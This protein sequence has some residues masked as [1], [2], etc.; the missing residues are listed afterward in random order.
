M[1][2][3]RRL[4]SMIAI[5]ALAAAAVGGV[6]CSIVY[7]DMYLSEDKDGR[8][9]TEYG[10]LGVPGEYKNPSVF[11]PLYRKVEPLVLVTRTEPECD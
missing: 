5:L 2:K 7:K 9:V 11:I 6:G 8:V 3:Q 10:L 1:T 4:R